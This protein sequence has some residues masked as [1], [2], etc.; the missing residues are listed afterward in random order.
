METG[1]C[2]QNYSMNNRSFFQY[3]FFFIVDV[4]AVCILESFE[5]QQSL[6]MADRVLKELG[7]TKAKDAYKVRTITK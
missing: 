6:L 1:V 7:K 2:R 5:N 4:T 3:I